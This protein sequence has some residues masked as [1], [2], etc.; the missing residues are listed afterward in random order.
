[1]RK[2]IGA[3]SLPPNGNHG[4]VLLV[5]SLGTFFRE[6]AV[7]TVGEMLGLKMGQNQ[8]PHV[9]PAPQGRTTT[10]L[11]PFEP[12]EAQKMSTASRW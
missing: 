4:P 2:A 1:M 6:V 3:V 7:S 8:R 10:P 12:P 5:L 11:P 9:F